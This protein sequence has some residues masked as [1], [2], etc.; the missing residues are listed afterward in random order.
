VRRAN[1]RFA[2]GTGVGRLGFHAFACASARL[3][4]LVA[5]LLPIS[6]AL[7]QSDGRTPRELVTV[8]EIR[9]LTADQA[10]QSRPVRLR[11]VVTVLSG[12]K[13]SFFFQD[14]TAGIS[15]DRTND[16]PEVQ[17]GQMVE[18]S[19]VTGSGLFAPIVIAES[20]TVLGKGKLP[21]SHLFGL[22]K[23]A[24]GGQDGQWIAMRGIVRSAVVK[25]SWG[26]SVLFLELDIGRG[27]MVTVRVHDF[28]K[29]GMDR[30]RASTVF[31]RGVCGTVFNDKRQFIGFRMFVANLGDVKMERPAPS[32]PF[33]IPT[34]P[35]GNLLQFGDRGGAIQPVK[36]RGIVTYSQPGQGLYIQDRLEGV[37]VQSQQTLPVVLGSELE[38]VG[39]PAAGRYSTTLENAVFRVAGAVHPVVAL[40]ETASGAIVEKDGF[41]VAP[42]DST[43]VKIRGRLVEE[44]LGTNEDQLILQDS[45]TVFTARLSRSG[46][47][48]L[49]LNAGSLLSVTGI[50]VVK[51]DRAL[52]SHSFE[53]LLRS[54]ADI[55]VV[56][57]APWWTASHALW[58]VVLLI[59]VILAMSGWLAVI[60]R[61]TRLRVLTV[62]DP[63]TGLY[64]RRGF[65]LLAEQQ[66]RLTLRNKAS[67]FLF[68]IGIDRF[69]EINDTLGHKEGDLALQAV[70]AVL[71]EGFRKSDIIGRIGGDEFAVIAV[72]APPPSWESLERRLASTLLKSN[73]TPGRKFQLT[74]SVGI[75]SCSTTLESLSIDDLLAKADALMYEQKRE[76]HNGTQH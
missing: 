43:L 45:G 73:N 72:D 69:K 25:P 12:W 46:R 41:A 14:S 3:L 24:G 40:P 48:R 75:L 60:R 56:E 61:Q 13:S 65:L 63:L 26:R 35:L 30:L 54:P 59:L 38:V 1:F 7:G 6:S 42:F 51:A 64:N 18:I 53:V 49:A 17:P 10:S 23:L 58:V 47:N 32:D 11:G 4:A 57:D 68:Y 55:L 39:Y 27:N 21:P 50:C 66:W 22:D 16:S 28:S 33:D 71:R 76:H 62:T 74:Q 37:F 44:L 36:V 67:F 34:R 5:V 19:G 8:K 29:G 31:I 70:A 52:E 9:S 20:V 15:V 2:D